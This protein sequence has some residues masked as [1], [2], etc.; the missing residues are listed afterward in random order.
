[1]SY[2]YLR[3]A[4]LL[5]LA[6]RGKNVCIYHILDSC[7]FGASRCVYSHSKEALPKRGWWNSPEKVAKV[8]EVLEVAEKNMKDQRQA[9]VDKWKAHVREMKYEAKARQTS[10]KQIPKEQ[11]V[12]PLDV[13]DVDTIS[14]KTPEI[15]GKEKG[16]E[17]SEIAQVKEQNG[18]EEEPKHGEKN[19]VHKTTAGPS[20]P[21]TANKKAKPKKEGRKK[22]EGGQQKK[23]G[24][25]L[26]LDSPT[27]PA[28]AKKRGSRY[29]YK[30]KTGNESSKSS[31]AAVTED[32]AN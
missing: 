13:S 6:Y 9:E 4:W 10:G 8:K 21:I 31:G 24:D 20:N 5:N 11:A 29:K 1:M 19:A 12:Q 17:K 22:V 28:A 15:I 26:N 18:I 25:G 32:N 14:E 23:A 3:R 2:T 27:S 30:N 16:S 7:K